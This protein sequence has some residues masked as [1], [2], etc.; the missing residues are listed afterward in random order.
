MQQPKTKNEK[1]E[2]EL[3]L[4]LYSV[5]S[6]KQAVLQKSCSAL[7]ILLEKLIPFLGVAGKIKYICSETF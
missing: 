6:T 7:G 1:G 5:R 2:S 4:K 3:C